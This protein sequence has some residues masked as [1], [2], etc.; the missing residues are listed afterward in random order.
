MQ[1]GL[2]VG[3]W[4]CCLVALPEPQQVL[5]HCWSGP[6]ME[7]CWAV[8]LLGVTLCAQAPATTLTNHKQCVGRLQQWTFWSRPSA[9]AA[10]LLAWVSSAFMS[11]RCAIKRPFG[12]CTLWA[13]R[14]GPRNCQHNKSASCKGRK[15][16]CKSVSHML[17]P[18]RTA[19]Y[20]CFSS[21]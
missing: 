8:P 18:S 21:S 13:H 15:G 9:A 17:M 2:L 4:A 20:C 3:A 14:L 12:G 19:H 16:A 1:Q 5:A 10:A 6:A 11:K 7:P